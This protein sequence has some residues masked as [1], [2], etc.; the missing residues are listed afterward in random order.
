VHRDIKP[1]NVFVACAGTRADVVKLL[2]FGLVKDPSAGA[3]DS[4]G[5]VSGTPQYMAPEQ[6]AA[7][8]ALDGRCDID[9]LGAVA[10]FTLTGHPP[11]EAR[12]AVGAIRRVFGTGRR[13]IP[14]MFTG[15]TTRRFYR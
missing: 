13:G 2:D 3:G 1:G 15:S 14:L 9:S 4:E 12:S 11:F 6:V 8:P 7:D 10:Y 5:A